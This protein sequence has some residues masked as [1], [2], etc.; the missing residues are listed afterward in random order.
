[1]RPIP[2]SDDL[3]VLTPAVN[4]NLLS[5]SDEEMS[6]REDSAESK[7]LKD[8]EFK[9]SGTSGNGTHW[10]AFGRRTTQI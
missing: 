10:N 7:S 2:H 6:S 8:I 5:L 9:Y 3:P 4:K 1:M